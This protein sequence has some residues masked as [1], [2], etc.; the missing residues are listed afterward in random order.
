MKLISKPVIGVLA[1]MAM[2]LPVGADDFTDSVEAAMEAYK[3]GDIKTAK[4]EIDFAAQ[5]LAQMKADG[6]KAFLPDA[7]DGW[8]RKDD[9]DNSG[10]MAAL[11]G[12]QMAAASYSKDG[13]RVKIQLMANNQMVNGLAAM[14]SNPAMMAAMGK[15]KR[16]NRQKVV[17]TKQDEIQTLVDNR[18]MIQISGNA[19]VEDKEAYF[20]A[21][22]VK[23]LKE[24]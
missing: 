20:K 16:L 2:V 4:E 15:V 7:L 3:N 8:E 1:V 22:D 23:E 5:I 17:I 11:G 19:D 24:F 12:G 9:R 13:K 21:I 10:A 14:F 18:I 6:L